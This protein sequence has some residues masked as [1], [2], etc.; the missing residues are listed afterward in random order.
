MRDHFAE[1]EAY[2]RMVPGMS[3]QA[4]WSNACAIVRAHWYLRRATRVG[5]KVRLWGRP[6]INNRGILEIADRVRLV[7]TVARL[8]LAVLPDG[9]LSIGTQTF[10][11][12]GCS[13]CATKRVS[14]GSQCSIGTH[15][16][17][18]DNDFHQVEPEFRDYLPPS[19]PVII[20]NN[21]WIG[22]RSIV[23]SG[24]TIGEWSV[25]GAGSVVTRA[26]PPRSL[27][28]GTPARI[29]REL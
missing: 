25:I 7:S 8:E 15:V 23:L 28:A 24:V 26:I 29:I 16:I 12:Y 19:S 21:V 20:G 9:H 13:I 14:I 3:W 10:I 17:I 6:V 2:A 1:L 4:V 5:A 11:N 22:A 27:A 18:M